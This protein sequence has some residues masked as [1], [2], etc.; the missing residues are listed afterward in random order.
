MYTKKNRKI[1]FIDA[2]NESIHLEMARNKKLITFGLGIND[3]KEF[4]NS[5][6]LIE[7]FGSKSF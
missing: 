7:K 5:K 4:L 1:T 3:P 2:I 6:G